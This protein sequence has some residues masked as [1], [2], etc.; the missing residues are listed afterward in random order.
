MISSSPKSSAERRRISP[1]LPSR[2]KFDTSFSLRIPHSRQLGELDELDR[3]G[4]TNQGRGTLTHHCWLPVVVAARKF[5]ITA[6]P[7]PL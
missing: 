4:F 2:L 3:L 5:F 7:L 1:L 6:T